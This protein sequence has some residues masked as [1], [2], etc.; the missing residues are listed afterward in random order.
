MT[1]Y[2][3]SSDYNAVTYSLVGERNITK[4]YVI[5]PHE[6]HK[7]LGL[8]EKFLK[9]ADIQPGD[10]KKIVVCTGPGSFTGV[11]VGIAH[12]QALGLAWNIQIG[13]AHV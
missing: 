9:S 4:T 10:I 7:A 12:A 5:D 8:M 2:I 1:L 3:E 13:R 6:S 11:R